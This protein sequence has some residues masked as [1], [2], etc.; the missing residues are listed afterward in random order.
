MSVHVFSVMEQRSE[1]V[2]KH[3]TPMTPKCELTTTNPKVPG[4]DMPGSVLLSAGTP[5]TAF[6]SK[7]K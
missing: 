4:I 5:L 1:N 7:H 6:D 2:G 3:F